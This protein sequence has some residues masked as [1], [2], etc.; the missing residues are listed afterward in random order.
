MCV[1]PSP[2]PDLPRVP[3]RRL[4]VALLFDADSAASIDVLRGAVGA[5]VDDIDRIPPHITLVPPVQLPDG[6]IAA[7]WEAVRRAGRVIDGPLALHL[8]PVAT[9]AP[10]TPTIHL[11]VSAHEGL[12]ALRE[13]S[14]VEAMV[15]P[16]KF[17][18]VPHV[19]LREEA[20][21]E[22]IDAA[23]AALADLSLDVEIR[24]LWLMQFQPT[25]G[26]SGRWEPIG[27]V[28]LGP[29]RHRPSGT[30]QLEFAVS[31]TRD[32]AT[33]SLIARVLD[34]DDIGIAPHPVVHRAIQQRTGRARVVTARLDDVVVAATEYSWLDGEA[35]IH[36]VM[37]DT[38]HRGHGFGRAVVRHAFDD[39]LSR[40]VRIVDAR[41][42][43]D[44]PAEVLSAYG[45]AA[46]D[47][48]TWRVTLQ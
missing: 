43:P 4:A 38:G 30:T 20:P 32:P 28:S 27:D 24:R 46:V 5:T 45:F 23:V 18:F 34:R 19:T 44:L 12:V 36:F 14:R 41:A 1:S 7:A 15:R 33:R 40:G 9:F 31:V 10:A 3:R 21:A 39:L 29:V 47:A 11:A 26:S 48:A 13:A 8:G 2:P 25:A 22:R 37:T 16:D 35:T 17:G 6:E 42:T